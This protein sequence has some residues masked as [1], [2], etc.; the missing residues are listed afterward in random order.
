M[1]ITPITG[2][3]NIDKAIAKWIKGTEDKITVSL[4]ISNAQVK[5]TIP[6]HVDG[7][8]WSPE[9]ILGYALMITRSQWR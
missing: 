2:D 9:D 3:L 8:Y 1:T 4:M 5:G 6:M 7:Y